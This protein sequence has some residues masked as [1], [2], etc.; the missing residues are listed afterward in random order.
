VRRRSIVLAASA[1]I[2]LALAS[3]W[4][5]PPDEATTTV[6][7]AGES[8]GHLDPCNCVDGMHGGFSRRLAAIA[9]VAGEVGRAPV[10]VDTGDVTGPKQIQPRLLEAK[11]RAALELLAHSGQAVM[12]VGEH[13]LR[14]GVASLKR[15]ASAAGVT[16][17]CANAVGD[18]GAHAFEARAVREGAP[19]PRILL[20]AVLDP[21]L[22][23]PSGELELLDPRQALLEL[24]GKE[25][26]GP[27]E[28]RVVL[29]HGTRERAQEVLGDALPVDVIVAGHERARDVRD[30]ESWGQVTLLETV[31]DARTLL[32]LDMSRQAT[33]TRA[34]P[35]DGT[36]PDDPWAKRRVD[37]YYEEVRGLPEPARQP[38]PEG[39]SFV[40]AEACASCHDEAFSAFEGTKHR[41]ALAR[42]LE[43]QPDHPGNGTRECIACHVTGYGYET[44][45][46]DLEETPH[47]GE[48]GCE[49]CH[50]VGGNHAMAPPTRKQG[51]G[52]RAGF[53]H[54][55]EPLCVSCHDPANS[56]E[57][58]FEAAME[59]IKHWDR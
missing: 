40:G 35:L 51:Y 54:S 6:L 48:V 17:L 31:R 46:V 55:W 52:V 21:E 20:T 10:V 2:G 53:P 49:A 7:V 15:L 32:R 4:A 27:D 3:S 1:L 36:V 19:G 13:D 5:A 33:K 29:F 39:G 34:L 22:E 9:R 26:R 12:A 11:T 25:E 8:L 16:L 59:R 50:G 42:T 41:G 28:R 58:D 47:L 23:D 24:F 38:I 45:F 37:A 56:P 30:P 57:F 44:G 14:L 43:A 18:D